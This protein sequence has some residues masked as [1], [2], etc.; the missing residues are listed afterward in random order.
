[1]NN[2]NVKYSDHYKL[3]ILQHHRFTFEAELTAAGI[4]Y[5]TDLDHQPS[6]DR[7]R[8]FLPSDKRQLIDEISITNDI[9]ATIETVAA[10]DDVTI[11]MLRIYLMVAMVV[12]LACILVVIFSK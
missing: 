4:D 9:S 11:K 6:M 12:T 10:V 2:F 7:I 5:Y 8:Y 1:M 3:Y